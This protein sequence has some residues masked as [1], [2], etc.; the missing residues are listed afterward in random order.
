M[1]RVK[2]QTCDAACSACQPVFLY[3]GQPL[4]QLKLIDPTVVPRNEQTLLVQGNLG[5]N[6]NNERSLFTMNLINC[7]IHLPNGRV[8]KN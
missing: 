8:L 4:A 1:G 6:N 5:N 7:T 2:R 3:Q